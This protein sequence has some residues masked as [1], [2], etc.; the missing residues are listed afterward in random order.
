MTELSSF[1]TCKNERCEFFDVEMAHLDFDRS[2][3]AVGLSDLLLKTPQCTCGD[4]FSL[5]F[6]FPEIKKEAGVEGLFTCTNKQCASFGIEIGYL[7]TKAPNEDNS[8]PRCSLCKGELAFRSTPSAVAK[9]VNS[10]LNDLPIEHPRV[11][12]VR[13]AEL[14]MGTAFAGIAEEAGLTVGERLRVLTNFLSAEMGR[15]AKSAIRHER[16]GRGDKPGDLE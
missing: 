3:G 1:L 7:Y 11:K 15:V 2:Q 12:I 14:T 5:R 4:Q 6:D 13:S 16:H 10:Y 8:Y 9:E